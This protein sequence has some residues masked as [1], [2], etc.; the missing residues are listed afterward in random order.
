[1]RCV[2]PAVLAYPAMAFDGLAIEQSQALRSTRSSISPIRQALQAPRNP[3]NA[4]N[5]Q[6]VG[7]LVRSS[8]V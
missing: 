1:M 8:P 3:P 5:E 7:V 2:L 6:G 4:V